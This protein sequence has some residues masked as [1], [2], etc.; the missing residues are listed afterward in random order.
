MSKSAFISRALAADSP[1]RDLLLSAGFEVYGQSLVKFEPIAYNSPPSTDWVFCY[2]ARSVDFFLQGLERHGLST[3][4]F[5]KY[6]AIGP[7]T[8]DALQRWSITP[9]FIGTG[10]PEET[11]AAFLTIAEGRRVLFPRAEQS[12]QS[13]QRLL[14]NAI[15]VADLVVYRNTIDTSVSLSNT[16]YA[17][18]TSPLNAQAYVALRGDQPLPRIVAI[19]KTTAHALREVGVDAFRIASQ[20]SEQA[21]AETVLGWERDT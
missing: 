5:P 10:Q 4:D 1:F 14:S 20:S 15:Q 13:V 9:H 19:G 7:G 6:A 2:S 21:L 12:R 11:A 17:A 16:D 3:A 8:A 18:L